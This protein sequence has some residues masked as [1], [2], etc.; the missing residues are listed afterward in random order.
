M[1]SPVPDPVVKRCSSCERVF[2]LTQWG[3]L[4][5]LGIQ[6]FEDDDIPPLELR[7]CMC[8]TTLAVEVKKE[9]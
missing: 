7:N 4:K 2:T 1:N 3:A 6:S 5:S 9:P 8:G